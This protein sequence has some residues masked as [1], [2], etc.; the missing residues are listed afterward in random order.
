MEFD[1]PPPY[2]DTPTTPPQPGY[3]PGY[4][5]P[6]QPYYDPSYQPDPGYPPPQHQPYY[7]SPGQAP[8]HDD[9]RYP[10]PQGIPGYQSGHQGYPPP[11]FAKAPPGGPGMHHHH[12]HPRSVQ[13]P[14]PQQAARHPKRAAH[15]PRHHR[16]QGPASELT[17]C[18]YI[19][20]HMH[21]CE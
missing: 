18:M 21:S 17:I 1:R 10:P 14:Q 8:Y 2:A 9:P 7:D 3:N 15:N 5:P 11:S 12:R 20:I 16:P 19:H 13:Y 6:Q 4:P